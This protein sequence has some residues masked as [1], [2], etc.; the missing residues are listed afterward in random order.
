MQLRNSNYLSGR[1]GGIDQYGMQ[2]KQN[3]QAFPLNSNGLLHVKT[4]T[5]YFFGHN[6][7]LVFLSIYVVYDKTSNEQPNSKVLFLE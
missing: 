7:K 1:M 5:L 6:Y 2:F 4:N 3:F